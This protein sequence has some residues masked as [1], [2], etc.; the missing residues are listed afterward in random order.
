LIWKKPRAFSGAKRGGRSPARGRLADCQGSGGRGGAA[1]R[2][3]APRTRPGW[4][5]TRGTRG[6]CPLTGRQ[7]GA[8]RTKGKRKS[9]RPGGE[10][11]PGPRRSP[12]T[13]PGSTGCRRQPGSPTNLQPSLPQAGRSIPGVSLAACSRQSGVTRQGRDGQGRATRTGRGM[14]GSGRD[15]Q[16]PAAAGR[17]ALS[18]SG[19]GRHR[20]PKLERGARLRADAL[21][22]RRC[23]LLDRCYWSNMSCMATPTMTEMPPIAR[24]R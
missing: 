2:R 19:E 15:G 8:G 21:L 23:T 5:T 13:A 18:G 3:E 7:A 12:W 11:G 4:T 16:V 1:R 24:M 6:A 22:L 14:A 20:R 9:R 17:I 10:R